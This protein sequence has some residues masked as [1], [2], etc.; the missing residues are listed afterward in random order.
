MVN[1]RILPVDL[2]G[3]IHIEIP[4]FEY[5]FIIIS[6]RIWFQLCMRF[7]MSIWLTSGVRALIQKGHLPFSERLIQPEAVPLWVG[8]SI[9]SAGLNKYVRRVRL[10]AVR[11]LMSVH[12]VWDLQGSSPEG[13]HRTSTVVEGEADESDTILREIFCCFLIWKSLGL[14]RT[15]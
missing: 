9:T 11:F 8:I 6:Y 10:R 13:R 12:L 15:T 1:S 7:P 4:T 5:K 2:T 14:L 3:L